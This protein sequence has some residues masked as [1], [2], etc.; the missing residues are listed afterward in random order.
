MSIALLELSV[1]D[2][3]LDGLVGIVATTHKA[4]AAELHRVRDLHDDAG[5]GGDVHGHKHYLV[6][7]CRLAVLVHR[8]NECGNVAIHIGVVARCAVIKTTI[9]EYG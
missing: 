1:D 4:G 9:N 3:E 5:G 7:V 6:P 8:R 2:A